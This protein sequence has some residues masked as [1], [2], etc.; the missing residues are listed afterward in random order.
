MKTN[1][2]N[3]NGKESYNFKLKRTPTLETN[4]NLEVDI[5]KATLSSEMKRK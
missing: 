1:F 5:W 2:E 3:S 4:R